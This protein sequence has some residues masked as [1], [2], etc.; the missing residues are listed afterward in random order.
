ML[1]KYDL[2]TLVSRGKPTWGQVLVLEF[3][4]KDFE[5]HGYPLALT[6]QM[7]SHSAL[8]TKPSA[9]PGRTPPGF[10][11]GPVFE[12]FLAICDER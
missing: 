1:S 3:M 9:S 8:H 11:P 5:V 12:Q 7:L 2:F 10:P 4:S 6:P